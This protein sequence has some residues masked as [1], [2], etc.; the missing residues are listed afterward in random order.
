MM[1]LTSTEWEARARAFEE[2]SEHLK[3][4]WADGITEKQQ[5]D[6]VSFLLYNMAEKCWIKYKQSLA[7]EKGK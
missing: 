4:E 2:A 5:G 3:Q 6:V 7:N 1:K